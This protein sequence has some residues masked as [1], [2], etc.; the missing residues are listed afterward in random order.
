MVIILQVY[1]LP[2]SETKTRVYQHDHLTSLSQRGWST[3]ALSLDGGLAEQKLAATKCHVA[4]V[5]AEAV[6]NR[7]TDDQ[8]GMT[9]E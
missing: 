9:S 7:G 8:S 6:P 4:S 3:V 5:L 2:V 1:H